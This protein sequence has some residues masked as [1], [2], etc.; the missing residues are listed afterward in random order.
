MTIEIRGLRVELGSFVLD[1][2]ALSFPA[3][4]LTSVIGPNGAGKSTLLRSM[5]S[6][7][8]VGAGVITAGGRCLSDLPG[9]VRAGLVGFVPQELTVQF[10]YTVF[11]FVLTGRAAYV[12]VL[13][14]PSER[15][16]LA[17]REALDYLGIGE[18][19][20]V[21]IL[22][23]SSG[24]RRLVMIARALAQGSET[25]ILDEPTSFL[26]PRNEIDAVMLM[27]RLVDE[28]GKTVIV[29]LHSLEMAVNNSDHIVLIKGGRIEACGRP[30]GTIDPALLK[31]IYQVDFEIVKHNGRLVFIHE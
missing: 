9:K 17:A 24:L 13:R 12:H 27:R 31:R 10:N 28:K 18:L 6:V 7:I 3:S 5:A 11:D 19:A 2:P 26:D 23:L 8:D 15:D 22:N 4:S 14:G 1:V 20:S 21:P 30:E 29:A 16:T 25:L